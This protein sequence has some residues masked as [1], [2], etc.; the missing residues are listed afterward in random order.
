MPESNWER[1]W[2]DTLLHG[3]GY[4]Y[5]TEDGWREI[6]QGPKPPHRQ[7]PLHGATDYRRRPDGVWEMPQ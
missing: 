5:V 1:A 2:R 6:N 7:P 4:M 3:T